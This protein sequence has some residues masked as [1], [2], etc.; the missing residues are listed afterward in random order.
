MPLG[1]FC[2]ETIIFSLMLAYLAKNT[3]CILI[4]DKNLNTK[5]IY[6]LT[7]LFFNPS[8]DLVS[9]LFWRFVVTKSQIRIQVFLHQPFINKVK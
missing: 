4:A 5:S 1:S 9:F 8:E 6:I 3:Y 2:R 7:S